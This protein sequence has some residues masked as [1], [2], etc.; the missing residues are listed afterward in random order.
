MLA[1]ID[2][3]TPEALERALDAGRAARARALSPRR[4]A[5][6]AASR[7]LPFGDAGLPDDDRDRRH[8]GRP[9]HP[10]P[11]LVPP[12]RGAAV[13]YGSSFAA[14]R[15]VGRAPG[16]PRHDLRHDAGAPLAGATTVF[17]ARRGRGPRTRRR[18]TS[19]ATGA[20]RATAIRLPGL[21]GGTA[22]T[23]PSYG[24]EALLLLQPLRVG[25]APAR[26]SRSARASEGSI[27]AYAAAVGRWL[28]TRDG[29]DFLVFYLPDYDYA[30]HLAGPGGARSRRSSAPTPA[31]RDLV[32]AAG[33]LDEFLERYAI[34]VCSDHGQTRGRARASGSRTPTPTSRSSRPRSGPAGDV[35][36]PP[37][38]AAGWSIGSALPARRA[39]ARRAARRRAGGRRRALPGG[40]L[41]GRPARR[42]GASLRAWR[43]GLAARRGR[44]RA[45]PGRY[46]NGLERAWRALACP[47]SGDVLVSAARGLGVR[48]P[49]RARTTS[50][51]AATARSSPATRSSR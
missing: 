21:A 28:V 4:A 42:R 8:P 33:G 24:P 39:R 1:V 51:A 36:A 11:R 40:R 17:E 9:P 48:R 15:A 47:T 38:T 26:R 45:R 32:E 44:G 46:P 49:R 7:R 22:G 30:S 35:V 27:D 10:A 16:A 50:A 31:S 34:V 29:F 20:G 18:S 3:L 5:T 2:G 43:R 12:R 13:E 37:R 6:R 25:R 14:M 41:G 19:R 23:R